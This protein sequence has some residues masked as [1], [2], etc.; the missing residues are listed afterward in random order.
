MK[1][2]R[3]ADQAG[4]RVMRDHV[5]T[6]LALVEAQLGDFVSATER[7]DRGIQYREFYGMYGL[8]LGWSY[9]A[10][11]RV[12]SWMKDYES[13]ERYVRSCAEH[14]QRGRDNP[15][16][17]A[18]YEQLM[19]AARATWQHMDDRGLTSVTPVATGQSSSLRSLSLSL[20][21][22][23]TCGKDRDE[24]ARLVL[25]QLLTTANCQDG[26]LYLLRAEGLTLA[27][28]GQDNP[29]MMAL[30]ERL[31]G[32]DEDNQEATQTRE[33]EAEMDSSAEQPDAFRPVVLTC[34]RG[35]ALATVGVVVLRSQRP[36]ATGQFLMA[37][38]ELSGALIDLG[39]VI[40]KFG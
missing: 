28:G 19:Q 1:R 12:A 5:E 9:E 32:A 30:A 8:N 13:F 15:A 23:V 14:Y 31:L 6:F 16:L 20:V 11:A 21:H 34:M 3:E 4:L 26:Q 37:A 10:R 24:R 40:P 2:V 25:A 39:D 27:A 17:A 18:R 29:E 33:A 7:L 35:H 38:R 22:S 36:D